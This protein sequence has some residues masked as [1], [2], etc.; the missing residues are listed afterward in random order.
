MNKNL[1]LFIIIAALSACGGKESAPAGK[2]CNTALPVAAIEKIAGRVYR[3]SILRLSDNE[4]QVLD[5]K[6]DIAKA[7]AKN[8]IS[9]EVGHFEGTLG[10]LDENCVGEAA[11]VFAATLDNEDFRRQAG[12][13]YCT[14][15]CDYE[16][17]DVEGR[18]LRKNN[19]GTYSLLI[20][21]AAAKDVA[22]TIFIESGRSENI[23]ETRPE[24]HDVDSME[25]TIGENT[26]SF[27]TADT[28][29]EC[30]LKGN[31]NI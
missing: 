20:E 24:R 4:A 1:A 27:T 14:K 19:D 31:K 10:G 28:T 6:I 29:T 15:I 5:I 18:Y 13:Y 3:P 2:N 23:Y 7:N 21:N 12:V 25:L 16:C 17:R 9:E 22:E 8:I 26:A 30:V 11:D